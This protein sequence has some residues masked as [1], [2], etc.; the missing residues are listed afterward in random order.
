MEIPVNILR[1]EELAAL[2]LRALYEKANFNLF[3]LNSFEEYNFYLEKKDFLA[4]DDVIK[5]NAAD[6][7]LLALNPDVTLSIVKNT[8]ANESRRL[9]YNENIYRHNR[10]TNEYQQ[11]NQAGIEII[12]DVC[13]KAELEVIQ[14]AIASLEVIGQAKLEFSHSGLVAAILALF[15]DNLQGDVFSSIKSKNGEDLKVLAQTANLK[16]DMTQNLLALLR[17]SGEINECLKIA[18]ELTKGLPQ[19]HQALLELEKLAAALLKEEVTPRLLFDLST[20]NDTNYYSGIIF[21]GFVPQVP[22]AIL[23]GGRYDGLLQS[24]GKTQ[25]AIG[26]GIHL[27]AIGNKQDS[28]KSEQDVINIALPKGRMG[29][30]IYQMFHDAGLCQ[31]NLL[32]ESRKLIF[33]DEKKQLR[34]FLVKP[35]DVASYVEHGAA[36]IGIVGRDILLETKANVLDVLRFAI[37]QCDI[38]IAGPKNFQK[39]TSRP[40]K[41]A[42]KYS[43][44]AR[45]YFSSLSQPVELIYLN[46]SIELAPLVGL[47]DVIVDIVETGTTLKENGLAV[48]EKIT[49]SSAHLVVNKTSWRFKQ[50]QI[51]E[52]IQKVGAKND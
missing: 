21:Q 10:H 3:C 35:S 25:A 33:T 44:I 45:T 42:T 32:D 1:Q 4:D 20:V 16:K 36:D 50:R 7:R 48:L 29:E 18:L 14:L 17:L 46:G 23:F 9:Y 27:N 8:P 26:F 52:I 49:D 2:K 22:Q 30:K 19:A 39:D 40:L 41:V 24:L 12:G 43:N 38:A 28:L 11:M 51:K 47:A 6:G 34:F 15:P 37:G 13:R 5:F 31:E